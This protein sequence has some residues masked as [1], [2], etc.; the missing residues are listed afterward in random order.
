MKTAAEILDKYLDSDRTKESILAAMESYAL[1]SHP[2]EEHWVCECDK[3]LGFTL[4][5]GYSYC[6]KCGKR[7]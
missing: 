2:A 3:P 7:Y 4:V 5:A 6:N 1:Q